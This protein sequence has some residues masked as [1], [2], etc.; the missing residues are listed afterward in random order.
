MHI[1]VFREG[2]QAD[3][4]F[5]KAI[6]RALILESGVSSAGPKKTCKITCKAGWPRWAS[7]PLRSSLP[8]KS[9]Q[10][11]ST[12]LKDPLA[13][14]FLFQSRDRELRVKAAKVEQGFDRRR[15]QG[16]LLTFV[17]AGLVVKSGELSPRK[18][19]R[20]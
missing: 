6:G 9:C 4:R 14:E 15:V 19:C 3:P 13:Q 16:A 1:G 17:R 2:A 20:A 5:G 12:G 8:P 11:V 7:T 18:I 10:A